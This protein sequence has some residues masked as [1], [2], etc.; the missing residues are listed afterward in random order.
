MKLKYIRK[1][2]AIILIAIL[3]SIL[4]FS[5]VSADTG[6][7]YQTVTKETITSGA[8]LQ[9]IVRFTNDGW[10]KFNVLRI[11]LFN[12]NINVDTMSNPD[13][14]TNLTTTKALATSRGAVA[15]IN[16][17][18][19]LWGDKTGIG[20]SVGDTIESGKITSLS[21]D[22]DL[23]KNNNRFT[24]LSIS[25]INQIMYNTWKTDIQMIS[26]TSISTPIGRYNKV[27]EGNRD[28]SIYDRRWG[29]QTL[30][31]TN[32]PADIVEMVVDNGSVV[33]IR[34][35]Q[36]ATQ[37]PVNGYVVV[38]RQEGGQFLLNNFKVGDPVTLSIKTT[39]DWSTLKTAITGGTMIVKDGQIPKTFTHIPE[40]TIS[41]RNPRTAIGSTKDGKQLLLMTVDGR[42]SGSIGVTLT[43]L[44]KL[45]QEFGATNAM[46]LDGGGSST[47]V[48][49]DMESQALEIVNNPSDGAGRKISTAL[50]IFAIAPISE[51]NGLLIN[52]E[53]SNIF[54]NT[55][56]AFTVKGFDR[57]YNPIELDPTKIKWS[58]S[59]IKGTF[60]D[61]VFYPTT[62]GSG[63]IIATYEGITSK[64]DISSLSSPVQLTL[65]TTSIKLPVNSTQSFTLYGKNKNGY[66][67]DIDPIDTKWVVQGG[68]GSFDKDTFTATTQGTGYI[69]AIVGKTH[70]YCTAYVANETKTLLDDFETVKPIF[71]SYP[72][73]VTG[74]F[75]Q[76][77][78]QKVSGNSSGKLTYNFSSTEGTRAAYFVYPDKGLALDK[79]A[80]KIGMWVY[81]STPNTDW[82]AAT[83][84]DASGKANAIYFSKIMDWTGWKYL[85]A[86]TSGILSP[87]MLTRVY[88]VQPNPV[89][90]FGSIYLDDLCYITSSY[91]ITDT[92][93]FPKD[94]VPIDEA[95]IAVPFK[96]N[97]TSMRFSV[98]G[99]NANP[100]N[101]LMKSSNTKLTNLFKNF[102]D[103]VTFVGN[104]S[105]N[106]IK[107]FNKPALATNFGFKSYDTKGNRFIQLDTTKNGMRLTDPNEWKWFLDQLNSAK[108]NNIFILMA[109]PPSSFSDSMEG[110]LFKEVLTSFKQ[111]SHKN[112]WVFYDGTKNESI[113]INGIKYIS[114]A[115][116][117]E[118]G[119]NPKKTDQ[120]KYIVVT[121][122]GSTITYV[123]K[124]IA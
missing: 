34:Q 51:L 10:L 104:S 3:I 73:T 15:A 16:T 41:T 7:I 109:G 30:G 61:N 60:K 52:S 37:I 99:Q 56:R 122:K 89:A 124:P 85:E 18:F 64:Y 39:P 77:T 48:A 93:K 110:D 6:L 91:K 67:A 5:T 46:N 4:S 106:A 72:T 19:F 1:S 2:I 49:R 87:T 108:G 102:Y 71:S 98:F 96:S 120:A 14:I 69:D 38:T 81:N 70:A 45:M 54:V 121:V 58:V 68:I 80:T 9:S 90:D 32:G 13:S 105:T 113:M 55:S 12:P 116:F 95:N 74:G 100:L 78:E 29:D 117:N 111:T 118:A 114:S 27:Y 75:E 94:T 33:E 107:P 25:T 50:G 119:L 31:T 22:F 47:M 62:V 63:T 40:G 28:F 24:T 101:A 82:L 36:P 21:P 66:Y 26:P 57:Y 84:T 115:G 92:S 83:I 112:I 79:N 17:G 11:D 97:S 8:T 20:Y 44:A 53:D 59:G 23:N 88:I 123:Y 76:S 65:N 43:E 86:P 103:L 42:Q 35:S